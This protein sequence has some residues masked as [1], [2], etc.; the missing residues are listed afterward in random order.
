MAAN[1][2]HSHEKPVAGV[3]DHLR[4]IAKARAAMGYFEAAELMAKC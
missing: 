3:L 4:E 2:K 1:A